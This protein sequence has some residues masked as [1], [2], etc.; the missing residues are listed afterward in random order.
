MT[1]RQTA[2]IIRLTPRPQHASIILLIVIA[3]ALV[4]AF[5]LNSNTSSA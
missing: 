1:F 4:A 5:S 2:T 3:A